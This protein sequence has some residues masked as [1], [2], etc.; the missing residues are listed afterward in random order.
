MTK[1][2]FRAIMSVSLMVCLAGIATVFGVLYRY[3]DGQLS[4]EVKNEAEYLAVAVESYGL[5]VLENLPESAERV[6]LVAPDGTVIFDNYFDAA[7]MENHAN[8]QEIQGAL[9]NGAAQAVRQSDTYR[10][11]MVY[12]ALRLDNGN[13]LRISTTQYTAAAVVASMLQPFLWIAFMLLMLSGLLAGQISHKI[14]EPLNQLDL[15]HPENNKSYAELSPLLTKIS[16]QKKTIREQ[17]EQA[18]KQQEEFV[19]ITE[20][21]QE[22]LLLIDHRGDILS[23]NR[24]AMRILGISPTARLFEGSQR[25]NVI[26]LNRSESFCKTVDRVLAGEHQ[27][28]VLELDGGYCQMTGN[29]VLHDGK[30]EG[31]V[32]LFIDVTQ[33]YQNEMLRRE[34]TANVSHELKTPLTS[35]SGFAEI[36]KDGF[37]R[38]E[39]IPQ[40]AGKIFSESQRLID[41]VGDIIKISQLDED[42]LP[43]EKETVDLYELSK[44]IVCRLQERAQTRGIAL[45]VS[46]QPAQVM[47]V[48]QIADEVIYN[49]CDN[50]IKY[51]KPQGT[52]EILVEPGEDQVRMLV[53]DTGIGISPADQRRVFERFYRVDKSHSKQ[54]GGTGLGLSIVKHAAAYLGVRIEL[55][56]TLG[57]GSC[58]SLTWTQPKEE[59]Q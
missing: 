59:L 2:I 1:R 20:D 3:F 57:Q 32:L 15:E 48:R 58:F 52:V 7:A 46:G 39:D 43:Y 27:E 8:R 53:R 13:I 47:T 35:I 17:L 25:E 14:V 9:Q 16:W 36:M 23:S 18:K 45:T 6:T 37:V 28:I 4:E 31:G 22:G 29:P 21:M 10:K 51:N 50:A 26:A 38:P 55:E 40:F 12:Y 49:L 19:L 11:Q 30:V 41:L 24:S 5:D 33:Q 54:I 42:M 44:E 34:F 56:S